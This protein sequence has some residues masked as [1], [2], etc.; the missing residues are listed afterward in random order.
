VQEWNTARDLD[1]QE[2]RDLRELR[3]EI[4]LHNRLIPDRV[5]MMERVAASGER[6]LEFLGKLND[7]IGMHHLW[8]PVFSSVVEQGEA[9]MGVIDA[10]LAP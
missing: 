3:D 1:Q 7:W 9:A 6:A 4:R 2:R 5:G 10:A 8:T